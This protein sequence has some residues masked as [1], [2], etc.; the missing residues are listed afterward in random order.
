M[1]RPLVNAGLYK[2]NCD[3]HLWERA[4]IFV[5]N[6]PFATLSDAHGEFTFKDV[7]PG[8]Y[9]LRVWHEGWADKEKDAAGRMDL[10]P[11]EQTLEVRVRRN[12]ATEVLLDSLI[13][14]PVSTP[15]R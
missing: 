5:A 1:R 9:P 7:P 4:W 11:M 10:Q 13:P 3:R 12:R 8:R 14:S 15:D 6:H 2:I